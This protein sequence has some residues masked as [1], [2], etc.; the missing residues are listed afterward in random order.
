MRAKSSRDRSSALVFLIGAV[1]C[2]E[3][4]EGVKGSGTAKTEVRPVGAFQAV[5]VSGAVDAEI[6][7]GAE[8]RVEVSGDDNIVSLID[9]KVSGD[10]LEIGNHGNFRPVVPLVV[11][12]TAPKLTAVT[13]SGAT[14]VTLRGMRDDAMSIT[15]HGAA[16]LHGDGAVKQLTVE[17][18]GAGTLDLDRLTAERATVRASGA[19][20]VS[21]NATQAL[22]VRVSGA[23]T[24][25]YRGNPELKQEVSGAG[26]L[27]KR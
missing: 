7:I 27:R 16:T 15:A 12:V 6:A 9:T 8:P 24:V 19:G 4:I 1:G 18:A 21:V 14:T 3:R 23:G 11:R 10:R 26:T 5:E 2:W 20:T 13:A 17:S 22:D 25:N